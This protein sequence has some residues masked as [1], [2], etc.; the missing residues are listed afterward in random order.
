VGAGDVKFLAVAPMIAGGENLLLFAVVLLIA[1][2]ATAFIVRNPILL[3]EGLFRQYIQHLDRKRVV[4]F[5][6]PISVALIVV[7]LLQ[8]VSVVG[9]LAR[10][11]FY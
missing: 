10:T 3:P 4:P 7:L 2:A 9:E 8:L 11:N 1:A 6:V 5:G